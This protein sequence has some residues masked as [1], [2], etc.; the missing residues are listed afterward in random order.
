MAVLECVVNVSTPVTQPWGGDEVLDVH[1]DRWHGRSV[2]TVVGEEAARAVA[3]R[4][5]R[6]IDLRRHSGVHPRVGAVDVVPFVPLAGSTMA[7]A[8]AARDRFAAWLADE[9]GVPALVY[10][11]GAPPLPEVRRSPP[12]FPHPTAGACCVGARPL[13]VAYNVVVDRPLAEAR[14]LARSLRSPAV[15]ALALEVG[16]EVQVSMN[17]VD[18]LAVGPADVFDAVG[19]GR[20]ELVGLVPEAVLDAV[21][22]RRWAELDLSPGKTIEARLRGGGLRAPGRSGA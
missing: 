20:A 21:P 6:T 22:E 1:A 19:G 13:L 12:P 10:G 2:V 11:E 3:R 5:V 8:V 7:D 15:R 17:L 9:L 14:R 16:D 18:P 4:A